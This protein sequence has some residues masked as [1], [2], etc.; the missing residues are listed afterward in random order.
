MGIKSYCWD[1]MIV[2]RRKVMDLVV[3]FLEVNI[4]RRAEELNA[5][6]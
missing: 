2:V 1:C 4:Q 3:K 5:S 6:S